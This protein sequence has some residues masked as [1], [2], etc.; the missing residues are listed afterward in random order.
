M[1]KVKKTKNKKPVTTRDRILK[2]G[3]KL[4]LAFGSYQVKGVRGP[5]EP[6]IAGSAGDLGT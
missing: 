5:M 1:L 4:A 3:N 2:S 6:R